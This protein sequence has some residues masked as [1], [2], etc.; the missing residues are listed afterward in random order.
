MWT[1]RSVPSM[2]TCFV[3]CIAIVS[4]VYTVAAKEA[5]RKYLTNSFAQ[6]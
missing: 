6:V 3:G 4:W 5:F 1:F 2:N